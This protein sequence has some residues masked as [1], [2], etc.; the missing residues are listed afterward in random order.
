MGY[1]VRLTAIKR[2]RYRGVRSCG[3]A[4]V[5]I[6]MLKYLRIWLYLLVDPERRNSPIRLVSGL[7]SSP[8]WLVTLWERHL[9][10][11]H[12]IHTEGRACE[13]LGSLFSTWRGAI[14]NSSPELTHSLQNWEEV[15]LS[16]WS[17]S[18]NGCIS[19]ALGHCDPVPGRAA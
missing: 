10:H 3:T 8:I 2:D 6:C 18:I 5:K 19:Y 7:I 9:S 4:S 13:R 12:E 15:N 14:G 1:Y 17:W 11:N 16:R